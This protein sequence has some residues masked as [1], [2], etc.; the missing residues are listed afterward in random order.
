VFTAS[1][2]LL[3]AMPLKENKYLIK[4]KRPVIQLQRHHFIYSDGFYSGIIGEKSI[5]WG[6]QFSYPQLFLD[7]KTGIIGKV[8][9]N[10]RFP[11]T[12]LFQ[13][14]TKWVRDNTSATP[15]CIKEKRVNQ[16]IRLGKKC[17]SW[18]NNHPEL[19]ERGL[20]VAARKNPS[21]TH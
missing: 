1:P 4:A 16:P 18:I 12:A 2:D 19:K 20:Y 5:T 8:E 9:K 10:D 21:T 11:N 7:T 13:R 3:Y 17:F 15:F 6:I 14:L